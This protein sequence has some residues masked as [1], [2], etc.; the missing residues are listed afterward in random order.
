MLSP[1]YEI[2]TTP[3]S[4]GRDTKSFVR[5]S[6]M[7]KKD[8]GWPVYAAVAIFCDNVAK[9]IWKSLAYISLEKK[10]LTRGIWDELGDPPEGISTLIDFHNTALGIMGW[11][12]RELSNYPGYFREPHWLS[13]PPPGYI[14]QDSRQRYGI[15]YPNG[16]VHVGHHHWLSQCVVVE[17]VKLGTSN[18]GNIVK[19]ILGI[20]FVLNVCLHDA[21]INENGFWLDTRYRISYAT[22]RHYRYE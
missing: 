2:A 3:M 12:V 11:R 14:T 7:L 5:D 22:G 9:C 10:I 21:W 8:M 17:V 20:L 19:L 4:Y 18:G 13:V 15:S 16:D 6:I 1:T